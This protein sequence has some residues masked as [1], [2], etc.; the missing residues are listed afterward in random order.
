MPFQTGS[1]PLGRVIET[2]LVSRLRA[3]AAS[4][5]ADGSHTPRW[6]FLVGGPGNGKSETVQD[7][8]VHLDDTL[9]LNGALVQLLTQRFS[10][11]GILPRKVEIL[12]IGLGTAS[13]KF[14]AKISRL[15]VIQDATA[16]ETALGNA[17]SELAHEIAD[18]ITSPETQPAPVFV[19]CANRGL[20]ARA[21]NEAFY[22]FGEAND[23]T[24]LL[25]NVIQASSLGRETL[26]GQKPCWP[27]E[28][29]G[30]FACWPLDVE[31]LLVNVS[32]IAPFEQML[33]EAT[34]EGQWE[35]TG[36]CGDCSSREMCP[37]RRT[38]SG[39]GTTLREGTLS[40]SFAE[41]NLLAASAGTLGMH[42]R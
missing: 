6:V 7:F 37:F 22:A 26:A 33:T 29:D 5:A 15:V 38:Q 42:C 4:I 21:M 10:P 14:G 35:V 16:T 13:A 11:A 19:A 8:L 25:A 9:G 28:D 32:G 1:T 2:S 30:R 34:A 36:R 40:L 17:A 12:P 24:Q 31:S 41:A 27:L 23:V 20:L 3:L 39:C 18:L